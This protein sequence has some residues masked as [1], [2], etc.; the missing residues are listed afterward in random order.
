M[1]TR[2]QLRAEA[3]RALYD[4]GD[5]IRQRVFAA[6]QAKDLSPAQAHLLTRLEPST[7]VTMSQAAQLLACD[8]SNVTGLTDRLERRGLIER[9]TSA[10]DRRVK[11]LALT[12]S[13]LEIRRELTEA[14]A[15]L[16]SILVDL[17]TD[18]LRAMRDL[19]RRLA[20]SCAG[21]AAETDEA[22]PTE[23]APAAGPE[24]AA[25]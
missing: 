17:S 9:Q 12:P 8:A 1:E 23:E 3:W 19:M 20:A 10:T 18:E 11:M 22:S 21:R 6:A 15:R 7:P 25:G 13:G 14:F 2:E 4:A 16:P 5:A 24:S